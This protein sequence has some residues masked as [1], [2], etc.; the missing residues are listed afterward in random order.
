MVANLADRLLE[1]EQ[2]RGVTVVKFTRR[3]ILDTYMIEALGEHLYNLADTPGCRVLISFRGVRRMASAH[4]GK[5]VSLHKRLKKIE[6]RLAFCEIH[7]DIYE[8][9]Q[10]F[11]FRRLVRIYK[12]EQDALEDLE[13][14][15]LVA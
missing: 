13:Q 9:F 8:I 11:G 2:V 5:L 1:V 15:S 12:S 4:L 10:L 14:V 3:D 6:G 7:P